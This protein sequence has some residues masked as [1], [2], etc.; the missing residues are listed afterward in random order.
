MTGGEGGGLHPKTGTCALSVI[1][2]CEIQPNE[3]GL[4][5]GRQVH[6]PIAKAWI[7]PLGKLQGGFVKFTFP[8]PVLFGVYRSR[9]QESYM[10]VQSRSDLQE[11]ATDCY[12]CS[13]DLRKD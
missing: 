6:S 8:S 1:C 9:I 7:T 4:H 5:L 11:T 13:Q 2:L 10:F 3:F 12:S